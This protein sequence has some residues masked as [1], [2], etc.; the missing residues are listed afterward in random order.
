MEKAF[1]G[2]ISGVVQPQW[3]HCNVCEAQEQARAKL[4]AEDERQGLAWATVPVDHF[5]YS[6][7]S[8]VFRPYRFVSRPL[9]I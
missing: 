1:S 3:V 7:P 8:E 9:N 4:A 5:P 6:D 2:S